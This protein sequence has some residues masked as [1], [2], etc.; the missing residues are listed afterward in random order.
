MRHALGEL[1]VFSRKG[2]HCFSAPCLTM[3]LRSRGILPDF[4]L[5]TRL[6]IVG[7]CK[8]RKMT[9]DRAAHFVTL[10]NK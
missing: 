5:N 9:A 8:E 1:L 4:L 2:T 3:V 7:C 6:S 10:A